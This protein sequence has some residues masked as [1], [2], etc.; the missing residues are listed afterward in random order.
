MPSSTG[1]RFK[2]TKYIPVSTA[3]ALLV[4]STTLFFVFTCPWLT[5]AISPAIP[6]Y[7]GLVFLFVLANFSMAT[8]M[9]PGVFPRADEDED[10]DDDFRA[11]LYKNVEIK[12]IQVRMKWCA[13]CHFYRPPRCSHCSVC[14]NCVEDF[15]HHCP[16]VNNCI[17]RRNYRYFFLFLLSLSTHMVGVFSFGLI[18][19]LNHMEKLGAAHT[20]ITMAVMCVTGLFFIPV[21]GLTG[22]HI[23]LVARGRTTNEQ[24]TGKFRGGVNPFTRG[25]CGN[26][27]HVLCSPLAPRYIVEPKKKQAVSVKPPFFRPD[28]SERQITVKISDNGIQANLNR[29]KSKVSLE[30]LE[31][32]TMD[33]QPPLPPKG[34][35]SKYSELKGQLGTSEES[36]LSPKLISPPTPAMYKYR[37]A[38]SNNPKVHY[39]AAAEQITMQE[40]HKQ[41]VLIEENNRSLD[42]QS[43][44]N[45]DIP[46][47][48]KSSL[49]KTYQSS[50]LQIDSFA[51]NSRSLSLKSASRRGTDKV[52]LHPIKSEGAASTPYKSIFSPNSLSNRNG[53]LSYDSLLNS[54]SPSG[55][56]CI[57][58]SAVGSVGYHSPYL[59]AKMCHLRGSELQRQ[60]PQSFSPVLGGPAPHQRDPSPVRYDNLSKTIMASIQERKEMEER[61]KLLL[62]H[63]DSVFADSGV[64]DT[65]SSYSLQQV[66]ALSED[67]R[68]MVMRYGSRDNLMTA[69]S[70]STRNPILQSS[71]SSLSSAMARAPRTSTTSLQADLA[72]NNVQSHQALQ[73]RVSNGSYKSPGHQ[74]PSSPTGMPR[75]PSYGGPKAVSFVNTVEITE[76]QSVG[77]Q[78]RE[79]LALINRKKK[80]EETGEE[81]LASRLDHYKAKATRHIFL[82]R[83]S[84]YNLDGRIDKDRILTQLGREQAEL[85]GRRLASLGLKF[86][87]IIHSSMTRATETTDIISKHLP[88]VKKVSTDLLREGAPIEPVPPVSHWKPEAVQYYEDGARIEAAFRNYIHRADAKQEEDSYEIFVC[89]ANVIRYI[90][91]RALQFP[92]EGWL[93]MSLNNG[94]ITHLVIRPSGRVALR[95]LGDTGFMPPDKITRT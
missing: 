5:R 25:C 77:A 40:G 58:H 93:R 3:A 80:N 36:G 56:K 84:Q 33:I 86:D 51:V 39:H 82:I 85:T 18:Y 70:F 64:Y 20:T 32:K 2:P 14:D 68:S 37:P 67:P 47:Y 66:S 90:V 59:S 21:I 88:G 57:A 8:F 10:K 75:S 89:H 73:A 15:D 83:H 29:S 16:W 46:N 55:R 44:P 35:L 91:C 95:T 1:K 31:D 42:Y 76:V 92:P 22:F 74:V 69:T 87:T 61:E 26:V 30:G 60:A 34:D 28:L 78:R 81:E 6:V 9:D 12:G 13:T 23:V 17:G 52:P 62:S 72:N 50:P 65:P 19:I 38:F 53:S 24:V 49:H 48:R 71:V 4:G 7:N 54:M 27:E 41:G 79:P 63:P 43:E 11:P 45:L 94:S